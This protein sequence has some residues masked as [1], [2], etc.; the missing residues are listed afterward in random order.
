MTGAEAGG[1]SSSPSV[2][3]HRAAAPDAVKCAVLTVSD[4][5][6]ACTDGS[7]SLINSL[8]TA[9]GHVVVDYNIVP[10]EPG[11]IRETLETWTGRSDIQA[12]ITNGGTGVAARDTTYD[13][14]A[15]LLEK[16]LD[17]FGELFRM[18]SY[19]EIGAA[20][21]MSRAVAGVRQGKLVVALP[22]STNAVRLAMQKL[23]LP[24]LGHLIYELSK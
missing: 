24:E 11:R 22:G 19:D 4:T 20:A 8:L 9:Q 1:R 18:L 15:A 10:D 3:Q 6:T 16:R 21:M 2:D 5:R 23:I 7:G 17:G 13:V 12:V 14:I